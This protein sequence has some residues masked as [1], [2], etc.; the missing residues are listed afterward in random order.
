MGSERNDADRGNGVPI[1]WRGTELITIGKIKGRI[2]IVGRLGVEFC[3][4]VES[5][6][7]EPLGIVE[8][9]EE[10]GASVFADVF[11]ETLADQSQ[12]PVQPKIAGEI[13]IFG[14]VHG[15]AYPKVGKELEIRSDGGGG[16]KMFGSFEQI[17]IGESGV[18]ADAYEVEICLVGSPAG[19][20]GIVDLEAGFDAHL[21]LGG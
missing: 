1:F 15:G 7:V 16:L 21:F 20:I 10:V 11:I 9:S 5:G 14:Y 17:S 4:R 19:D 18:D 2:G 12:T 8:V 6:H 13:E 3:N